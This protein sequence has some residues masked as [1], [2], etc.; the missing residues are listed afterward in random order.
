MVLK[1]NRLGVFVDDDI[2]KDGQEVV[3][4]ARAELQ[5]GLLSCQVLVDNYRIKLTG[6]TNYELPADRV[7]VGQC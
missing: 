7:E 1:N 5:A 4:E 3:D 6:V 2:S